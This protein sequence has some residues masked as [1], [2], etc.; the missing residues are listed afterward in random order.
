MYK[1]YFTPEDNQNCLMEPNALSVFKKDKD[2]PSQ[3]RQGM[4]QNQIAEIV[5]DKLIGYIKNQFEEV[6]KQSHIS[7]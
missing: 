4:P 6:K 2:A 7:K 5:S 3:I 1:S